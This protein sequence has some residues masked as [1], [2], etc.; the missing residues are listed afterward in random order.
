MTVKKR[1]SIRQILNKIQAL[2]KKLSDFQ[3]TNAK[4]HE[5]LRIMLNGLN[6][7]AKDGQRK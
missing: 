5:E 6:G 7:S 1:A 4:E 2:E 3:A